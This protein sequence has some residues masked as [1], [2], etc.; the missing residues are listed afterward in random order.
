MHSEDGILFDDFVESSF[1]HYRDVSPYEEPWVGVFHHLQDTPDFLL[2]STQQPGGVHSSPLFRS[3]LANLKL[4]IAL[5][6]PLGATLEEKL[7]VPFVTLLHPT[8]TPQ[9][10]F[11]EAAFLANRKRRI[12]QGGWHL[13]NT[14]AI[15][16]LKAPDGY[17]KCCLLSEARW[18]KAY[19]DHIAEL[20]RRNNW[21]DH[22]A[23]NKATRRSWGTVENYSRVSNEIYDRLLSENVVFVEF[24]TAA[25]NNAVVECIVRNTPLV[26]NRLP[27]LEE[28]LGK[29]YPLFYERIEDATGLFSIDRILEGHTY[30]KDL[31]KRPFTGKYFRSHLADVLASRGLA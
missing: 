1:D 15:Y 28:Y 12:I 2:F 3:S 18:V 21:L 4:G 19:R 11:S 13:R 9:S 17:T 10:V 20:W 25:A 26:V 29:D 23:N 31:D 27:A 22:W 30:L 24:F 6:S 14:R 8:E 7:G 16:Q 5:S